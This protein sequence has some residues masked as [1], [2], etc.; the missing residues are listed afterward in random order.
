MSNTPAHDTVYAAAL[1]LLFAIVVIGGG[2]LAAFV[3]HS[4][5]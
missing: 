4:V 3:L 2:A 5:N 1:V